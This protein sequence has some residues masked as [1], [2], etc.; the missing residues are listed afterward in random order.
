MD[1]FNNYDYCN[2]DDGACCLTIAPGS[3]SSLSSVGVGVGGSRGK[4]VQSVCHLSIHPHRRQ[5]PIKP[6]IA[7]ALS[8]PGS[9]ARSF[10]IFPPSNFKHISPL[11]PHFSV[12]LKLDRKI[13]TETKQKGT[14][15]S[16]RKKETD[17]QRTSKKVKSRPKGELNGAGEFK[18]IDR[19]RRLLLRKCWLQRCV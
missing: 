5:V 2:P 1:H 4:T 7:F 16:Q 14:S 13:A 17:M 9:S 8:P 15:R 12:D 18:F 19:G 3:P 11:F 10:F 6:F